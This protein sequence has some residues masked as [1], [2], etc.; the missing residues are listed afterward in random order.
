MCSPVST[1]K[2]YHVPFGAEYV[3][4]ELHEVFSDVRH[5]D[6]GEQARAATCSIRDDL[7]D[8]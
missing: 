4:N 3:E 8:R 6:D 2:E 1:W 5:T 7:D